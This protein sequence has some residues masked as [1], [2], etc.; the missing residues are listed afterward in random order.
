M[1]VT[2]CAGAV[3]VHQATPNPFSKTSRFWCEPVETKGVTGDTTEGALRIDPHIMTP[4]HVDNDAV[5]R[6][7]R[8]QAAALGGCANSDETD[9][10]GPFDFHVRATLQSFHNYSVTGRSTG[11]PRADPRVD[12]TM[13]VTISDGNGKLLDELKISLTR[14]DLPQALS[15]AAEQWST[16]LNQRAGSHVRF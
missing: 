3:I 14:A 1:L 16:Y 12:L 15:A 13:R 5:T 9:P 6:L 11:L 8:H 10:R 7:F 2:S 4:E